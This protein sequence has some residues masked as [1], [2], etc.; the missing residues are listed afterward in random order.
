MRTPVVPT[1]ASRNST[2]MTLSGIR[3]SRCSARRSSLSPNSTP[4]TGRRA[5]VMRKTSRMEMYLQATEYT[6]KSMKRRSLKMTR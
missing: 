1:S 3:K 4:V 2:A 5:A 6:E